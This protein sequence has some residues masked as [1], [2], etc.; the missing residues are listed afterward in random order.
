MHQARLALI[1]NIYRDNFG[2]T[3]LIQGQSIDLRP[4]FLPRIVESTG[5]KL[6]NSTAVYLR[7]S[8]QTFATYRKRAKG[9]TSLSIEEIYSRQSEI[10]NTLKLV[11]E[12]VIVHHL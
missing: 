2:V 10:I 8:E 6:P 11:F 7:V 5:H 4:A 12:N 1:R 9:G 3:W